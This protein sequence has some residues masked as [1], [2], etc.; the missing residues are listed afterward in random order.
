MKT[1]TN[2]LPRW[3]DWIV[4]AGMFTLVGIVWFLAYCVVCPP[5]PS[6]HHA[7]PSW[8]KIELSRGK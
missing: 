5:D 2:R 1:D 8:A 7:V 6:H 3:K 4:D